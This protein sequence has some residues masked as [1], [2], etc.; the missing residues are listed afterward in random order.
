MN[1][2]LMAKGEYSTVE[3]KNRRFLIRFF[4]ELRQTEIGIDISVLNQI[5]SN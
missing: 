5:K 4:I 2:A 1:Q 3:T